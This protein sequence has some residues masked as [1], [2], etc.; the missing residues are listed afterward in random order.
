MLGTMHSTIEQALATWGV[1]P[2]AID[3]V[4]F[5]HLHVQDVRGLLAPGPSGS[6]YLPHAKLLVQRAELDTLANI[7]PLQGDWYIPECLAGVPADRIVALDGDYA[8]GGGFALVRTPGHT[9]GNHSLVVVTD[10]GAW[11]ISENGV[12]VDAYAP[13]ISAIRGLA[14][15]RARHRR[16]GHP[17]REHPRGLA[18]SVHVDG[19][20]ED[21]R[22]P[23]A[24]SPRAPPALLVVGDGAA[25]AR[26]RPV[27][28]VH[29]R[30]DH[31][32]RH[33][34]R[35]GRTRECV[36]SVSPDDTARRKFLATLVEALDG[37]WVAG[38]AI[39]K[40][41]GVLGLTLRR[42]GIDG[43]VQ[44]V[45]SV[46]RDNVISWRPFPGSGTA[47]FDL[48]TD[49][50]E[51]LR[52]CVVAQAVTLLDGW[53]KAR[54]P[55]ARSAPE[56][57]LPGMRPRLEAIARAQPATLE[58]AIEEGPWAITTAGRA[59]L[60]S[61]R[62]SLDAASIARAFPRDDD[63]RLALGARALLLR[64]DSSK[65]LAATRRVYLIVRG[66]RV[67]K[68]GDRL[69]LDLAD[70]IEDNESHAWLNAP[71]L[72]RS[73]AKPPPADSRAEA[74]GKLVD[75][76][77]F[78]EAL[79]AFSI[80][81]SPSATKVLEGVPLSVHDSGHA[82]AWRDTMRRLLWELSP[83][84]I[85]KHIT[86]GSR[87]FRT[88]AIAQ[89]L[90]LARQGH[91]RH[92]AHRQQRPASRDRVAATGRRRSS[93]ARN[94]ARRRSPGEG[95]VDREGRGQAGQPVVPLAEAIAGKAA[96]EGDARA[97]PRQEA[98]AA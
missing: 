60:A 19:A 31:L 10:R 81:L 96:L 4:T 54:G 82:P 20:R 9:W 21:A 23:R 70:A 92:R 42:E 36:M 93:A 51:Y 17:Q 52:T 38:Y 8:I 26:A 74:Y 89:G 63:G 71:W 2:D 66:P 30:R 18:R 85:P 45:P 43:F 28:D 88:S 15:P 50:G 86:G 97:R 53:V 78:E 91:D 32:R 68:D 87:S 49:S 77:R 76:G 29:P 73:T 25:R 44:V 83:W 41:H 5:D 39:A 27:A 65:R 22:G 3:Y 48:T 34:R 40:Q 56:P 64:I 1:A 11:T 7:H 33:R 14:Q 13:G 75:D 98:P 80:A 69:A 37:R 84:L 90:D 59:Q 72:W 61:A 55:V 79:A 58:D 35:R 24:R 46:V 57:M 6:A 95:G 67:R 62:A 94:R 16:R 12:C 47:H